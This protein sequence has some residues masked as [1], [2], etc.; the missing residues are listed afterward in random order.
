MADAGGTGIDCHAIRFLAQEMDFILRED[1][2]VDLK[3]VPD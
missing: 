3:T 2:R 1:T